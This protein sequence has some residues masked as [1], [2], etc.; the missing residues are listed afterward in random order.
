MRNWRRSDG[1]GR[2]LS[3]PPDWLAPELA[4]KFWAILDELFRLIREAGGVKKIIVHGSPHADEYGAI[5]VLCRFGCRQF[6]GIARARIEVWED[7][8]LPEGKSWEDHAREGTILIGLGG[9]PF[10]EHPQSDGDEGFPGECATTLVARAVHAPRDGVA[11]DFIGHVWR[12]DTQP[13]SRWGIGELVKSLNRRYPDDFE[14]VTRIVQMTFRAW[15]RLPKLWSAND[16]AL[17]SEMVASWLHQKKSENEFL[18]FEGGQIHDNWERWEAKLGASSVIRVA[19][20]LGL[21]RYLELEPFLLYAH[22]F[23]GGYNKEMMELGVLAAAVARIEGDRAA[24]WWLGSVLDAKL[25]DQ[26][27]F[28]E[29]ILEVNSKVTSGEC[30]VGVITLGDGPRKLIRVAAIESGNDRMNQVLQSPMGVNASVAIVR[31]PSGNTAVFTARRSGVTLDDVAKLIRAAEERK[32]YGEV[33]SSSADLKRLGMGKEERWYHHRVAGVRGSMLLNG[34]T[35]AAKG[36]PPT[37]LTLQ[38]VFDVVV[39][40]PK[41]Q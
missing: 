27:R 38:E 22:G 32:I 9:S 10:D 37:E 15:F 30:L 41:V 26:K 8:G 39:G 29:A 25:A 35:Q 14:M 7:G 13:A 17:F 5:E 31:Q 24:I 12:V 1:R 33:R 3:Y 28:V 4:R 34:S 2:K 19:H 36:V 40:V 20:K 16:R 11:G 6:P 23:A 21:A 18:G